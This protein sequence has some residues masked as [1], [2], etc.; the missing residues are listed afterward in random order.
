LY[1]ED[2]GCEV[3][4]YHYKKEPANFQNLNVFA[5]IMVF[6]LTLLLVKDHF[7]LF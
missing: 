6:V 3:P 2:K 4:K 5:D 7:N 1:Y